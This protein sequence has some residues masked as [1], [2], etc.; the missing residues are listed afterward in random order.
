[1]FY[2][3]LITHILIYNNLFYKNIFIYFVYLVKL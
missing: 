3:N 1:M 2:T